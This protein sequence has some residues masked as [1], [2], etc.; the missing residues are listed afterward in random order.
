L[1]RHAWS[2]NDL[3]SSIDFEV[4]VGFKGRGAEGATTAWEGH[5]DFRLGHINA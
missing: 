1:A 5:V 2:D 4:P 3:R